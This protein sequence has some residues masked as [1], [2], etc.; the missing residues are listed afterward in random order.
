MKLSIIASVLFFG[1]CK[2]SGQVKSSITPVE[3]TKSISEGIREKEMY[4]TIYPYVVKDIN[5]KNFAFESLKGK[6]I[7]VV[8]TASLCGLTPQYK[9]LQ[10]LYKKYGHEKLVIVGFPSNDFAEQEPQGNKEIMVFCKEN[11]GVTFPMMSKI[12]V[13]GEQ[14]APIYQFLTQKDKNLLQDS[15]VEWNFQKYLIDENGRLVKV[16][17]SKTSPTDPVILEW[18]K[19]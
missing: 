17:S 11:Y 4:G 7:M 6:K 14:M 12:S 10:D 1:M 19:S 8:N 16:I 5:G 18:L 9:E 15:T 3:E 13:T 2:M